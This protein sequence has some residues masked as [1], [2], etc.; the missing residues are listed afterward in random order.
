MQNMNSRIPGRLGLLQTAIFIL[1]LSV[2]VHAQ[3]QDDSLML[4]TEW[5]DEI[6]S[7]RMDVSSPGCVVSIYDR[8]GRVATRSRGISNLDYNIPLGPTSRFYMASI[9][10]QV[11]SA[12]VALLIERGAF[13]PDDRVSD[14]LDAWPEWAT[15]VRV[16]HLY[17]HTSGLSDLYGLLELAG[18]PYG[19][20]RTLDQYMDLIRA[21]GSLMF[22]PGSEYSYS[23]SGYTV[24]AA[25]VEKKTGTSFAEAVRQQIL[26][27]LGM[28]STHFHD[29]RAIIVPNRVISYGVDPERGFR[30]TYLGSFQGVGPGGLYSS[31][32][33]WARWESFM[34]GSLQPEGEGMTSQ[35]AA[36][37]RTRMIR[38]AE[39]GGAPIHYGMGLELQTFM[40]LSEQGHS[41]SFMGFQHDLRRYP[42]Q[43]ISVLTLCNRS[44][45][46]PG[47]I[48]R[49]ILEKLLAEPLGDWLS[50][51]E[52]TFR[53]EEV[54]SEM[55]LE[56]ENGRLELHRDVWPSGP[57]EPTEDR[58]QWRAGSWELRFEENAEGEIT[59]FRVYTGRVRNVLF[60]K[61]S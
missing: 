16:H 42:E 17:S 61:V 27:P 9:S 44:D 5:I 55:E 26:L 35:E 11:T 6:L 22:E 36:T 57:L 14:H 54:M 56:I 39:A 8:D 34:H 41:G 21:S 20:P 7:E 40:G 59:G 45:A 53:S 52:G 30:R 28:E 15:N 1:I 51:F 29:D 38:E 24:L 37:I 18:I 46:E 43:N 13:N 33:D 60:E 31:P 50:P 48:N 49:R 3:W 12:M 2:P 32:E 58:L 25:L 23:N 47:E 4:E 10:K 19:D